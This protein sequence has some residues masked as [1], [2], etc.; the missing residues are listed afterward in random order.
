MNMMSILGTLSINALP[1]TSK[2]LNIA[3]IGAGAAGL[4]SAKN[5]LE[6][7]HNVVIYEKTE[8]LGGI[9]WYTDKTGKDEYGIDI[10]TAMYQGLRTT[11]P[12]QVMEYPGHK[13]P[14][15]TQSYPPH[16]EVLKYLNSYAERFD[17]KKHI[18]FHHFVDK[19]HSIQ[20]DQWIVVVKDLPNSR[21]VSAIYD[22]VF[23][24]VNMFSSPNYPQIEGAN[25]F[26]G[27]IIHS[28][29]YR[30]AE[31]FRGAD[32]LL[33]GGGDS[34]TDIAF[35]L[36]KTA[37]RVTWS[38]RKPKEP[39]AKEQKG[40]GETVTFKNDV[41][42]LT[43]NGAEFMDNT[44]QDFTVIIYATGYRLSFPMLDDDAGI[45]IDDNY[46]QPLYMQT[47]NINHT[48]MAFI[49]LTGSNQIYDLKA[50]FSLKF[51]SGAKKLPL[52]SEMLEE[53]LNFTEAQ[54]K[55]DVSKF[56]YNLLGPNKEYYEKMAQTAD[57]TKITDVYMNIYSDAYPSPDED[58]FGYR[59]YKY[60]IIDDKTFIK[61]KEV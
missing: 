19:I 21:T 61:E 12:Y 28:H 9:W 17:L 45:R 15:N 13:Y 2:A 56:D 29:D 33:I 7:G 49:G 14:N 1:A 36:S 60:T 58:P 47:L 22:A 50:R 37:N 25:E 8:A 54:Q 30:R 24:C 59:Q 4:T 10:H 41:K 39:T 55:K 34:G 38:R 51:I 16:E 5:A 53:M 48:T 46:L 23:V 40:Y 44:Q 43:S 26:K 52:K 35:Q 57:I 42:L 11:L 18:K 6:Q 31:D 20:N 3:V 27:K 32:V